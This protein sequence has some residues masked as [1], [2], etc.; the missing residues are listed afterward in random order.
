MSQKAV[1]NYF[2]SKI[3]SE[4]RYIVKSSNVGVAHK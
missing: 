3:G 2:I 4:D 1:S